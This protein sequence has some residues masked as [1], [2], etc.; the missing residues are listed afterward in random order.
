[1]EI[2]ILGVIVLGIYLAIRLVAAAGS[3]AAGK[4]FRAYRLLANRY[5]GRY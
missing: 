2:L 3:W 1:M 5:H 4:R